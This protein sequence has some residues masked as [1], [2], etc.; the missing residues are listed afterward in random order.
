ML[1]QLNISIIGRRRRRK[2][3]SR[4]SLLGSI[5][6]PVYKFFGQANGRYLMLQHLFQVYQCDLFLSDEEVSSSESSTGNEDGQ[7]E[8][9]VAE[10]SSTTDLDVVA[11]AE[12]S[13][14]NNVKE[15]KSV[16]TS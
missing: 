10:V 9:Q 8:E 11:E 16:L 14:D 4:K 3:T 12:T 2:S 5:F 7:L 6:S 15:S 13:E 1:L